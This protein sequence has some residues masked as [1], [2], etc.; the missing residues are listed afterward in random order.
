MDKRRRARVKTQM[1][2][3]ASL[4]NEWDPA[5]LVSAGAPADEYECLVGPLLSQLSHGPSIGEL[6]EWLRGHVTKHFGS[7]KDAEQ[8]AGLVIAWDRKRPTRGSTSGVPHET[9][10]RCRDECTLAA[11]RQRCFAVLSDLSTYARWWTLVAVTPERGGPLLS[12]GVR[13]RFAGARPGGDIVEWSAEVLELDAPARIELA[14]AGGAYVGRTAFELDEVDG[15]TRVAYV[16]R[17]VSPCSA[18][19]VE[20]FAR[21]GTRLHSVAM[22]EDAFAGLARFLGG[23]GSEL[24]DDAWRALVR[25]KVATAIRALDAT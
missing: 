25:R 15:G 24:D 4:V 12:P 17:G 22:H 6:R 1:T 9:V 11:P 7:C 23:A 20:H 19:A 13:F 5:H 16:Y 10:Y 2:E 21:W 3:L 18:H 8:F 14:Y